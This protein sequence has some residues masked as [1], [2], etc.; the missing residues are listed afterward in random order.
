[1]GCVPP[2]GA[3]QRRRSW[4]QMGRFVLCSRLLFITVTAQ[5]VV[6]QRGDLQKECSSEWCWKCGLPGA[7]SLHSVQHSLV[8][9]ALLENLKCSGAQ[10]CTPFGTLG[11]CLGT[12][13]E[14]LS[15][16]LKSF[17]EVFCNPSVA[18]RHPDMC[19]QGKL[20]VKYSLAVRSKIIIS[21]HTDRRQRCHVNLNS[22]S[23][24]FFY[25]WY[26]SSWR[27]APCP[28]DSIT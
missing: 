17:L 19:L 25:L 22:K 3:A 1:M 21:Q 20:G 18:F 8:S 23:R 28:L 13:W 11:W 27:P 26:G 4:N 9:S 2:L 10:L 24:K 5:N 15:Q 16:V 14:S 6:S 7:C 12:V